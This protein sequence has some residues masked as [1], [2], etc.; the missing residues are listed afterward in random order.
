MCGCAAAIHAKI[1]DGEGR[2]CSRFLFG[3]GG[4]SVSE[5]FSGKVRWDGIGEDG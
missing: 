3:C 4:D 1:S 2:G 5:R